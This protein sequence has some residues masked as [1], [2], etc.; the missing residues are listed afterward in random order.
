MKKIG[1]ILIS[2]LLLAAP[3]SMAQ[4]K[5]LCPPTTSK[6]AE[7]YF[8]D[9]R[10]ARKIKKTFSVVKEMCEKALAEDS[11]YADALK[12]LGDFCLAITAR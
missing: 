4:Q 8:G 1:F 5:S 3:M 12:L 10:E 2:I 6:K 7:K 9:A 11:V